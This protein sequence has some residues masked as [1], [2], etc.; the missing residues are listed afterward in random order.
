M[1]L[2]EEVVSFELGNPVD[3]SISVSVW[4]GERGGVT[5]NHAAK[6]S[7]FVNLKTHG[8][9]KMLHDA[10]R[11]WSSQVPFQREFKLPWREAGSLNH[12]DDRVDSD[13]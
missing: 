5:T 3:G 6:R 10:T 13:Q 7:V 2:G 9:L 4:A 1:V 8:N 11:A 12:P